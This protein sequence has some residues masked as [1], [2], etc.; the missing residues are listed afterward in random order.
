MKSAYFRCSAALAA[1]VLSAAG[2][3]KLIHIGIAVDDGEDEVEKA[4]AAGGT[5][6][7]ILSYASDDYTGVK[8]HDLVAE[9]KAGSTAGRVWAI[10]RELE[11]GLFF[12]DGSEWHRAETGNFPDNV[13][14]DSIFAAADRVLVLWKQRSEKPML[15]LG[16]H[17]EGNHKILFSV[18][19][20]IPEPTV[21]QMR[22]GEIFITGRSATVL[23]YSGKD[24]LPVIT[25]LPEESF[26][27]PIPMH[28]GKV[29]EDY[30][31]VR[32][33]DDETGRYWIWSQTM[34]GDDRRKRLRG[35]L[36]LEGEDKF[37][38]R[39]VPFVGPD[40]PVIWVKQ[41]KKGRMF[42]AVAG[43]GFFKFDV[44]DEK[45]NYG[46]SSLESLRY[47]ER[48]FEAGGKWYI[49]ATPRPTEYDVEMSKALKSTL[50]LRTTLFYDPEVETST[51][52]LVDGDEIVQ[53][54]RK[55]DDFPDFNWFDR[56]VVETGEGFWL[57]ANRGKLAY[58]PFGREASIRYLSEDE[59]LPL[60][61]PRRLVRWDNESMIALDPSSGKSC[62]VPNAP[63]EKSEEISRPEILNTESMLIEDTEGRVFGWM[64][65][66][67][68]F[69]RWEDGEWNDLPQPELDTPVGGVHLAA[70][71]HGRGWL[72]PEND[73]V[74]AVFDPDDGEWAEFGSFR[75]ALAAKMK[76]ADRIRLGDYVGHMP[77][78]SD[79][80]PPRISF[81]GFDANVRYFDGEKWTQ[82]PLSTIAGK[83]S[84]ITAAPFFRD[85]GRLALPIE[86]RLWSLSPEG[87]WNKEESGEE[88]KNVPLYIR[89]LPDL[90]TGADVSGAAAGKITGAA[91]DR[92]GVCWISNSEGLLWK[93]IPGTIVSVLPKGEESP[94]R[95]GDNIREVV[96]DRDGTAFLRLEFGFGQGRHAVIERRGG[97][98]AAEVKIMSVDGDMVRLGL[99]DAFRHQW[100]I[101]GGEWSQ[102]T[103]EKSVAVHG[104][105][106]GKHEIE[107]R[108]WTEE[109]V[110]SVEIA[111]AEFEVT[112]MD[113][114]EFDRLLSV[115]EGES[116]L[117]K[118]EAARRIASQGK[119]VLPR[120]AAARKNAADSLQWWIDAVV[121]RVE[122]PE[123]I[124]DR[125]R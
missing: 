108:A 29:S 91:Y 110:S 109:L 50:S 60:D 65:G 57:C 3:D 99:G 125:S 24:G 10:A 5:V 73:G 48:V 102:A 104:L 97:L 53:L 123:S 68:K 12:F 13:Y 75:E 42:F 79:A 114:T 52:F 120:L 124:Q 23:R 15:Y 119:A 58:V 116:I 20:T 38:V 34:R 105:L 32:V 11:R 113:E 72:V 92:F 117:E 59:G 6:Y 54:T 90:P 8:L 27:P 107:A 45:N 96:V 30:S 115:F 95:K 66:G 86:D 17:R 43:G 4:V 28:D 37:A 55:L 67:T 61:N 98:P 26:Y 18:P 14:P 19:D 36:T 87:E 74:A 62:L 100:R 2:Q 81:V 31:P 71:G 64:D 122:R 121:Q 46:A 41:W 89:D 94:L 93:A 35:G 112:G 63:P 88:G 33:V 21:A 69:R 44:Q 77:V 84:K 101:N 25:V 40:N 16:E 103:G 9:Q 83:E 80:D 56:S 85:D 82:F 47:I 78:S 22:S 118:E 70:D 111:S 76:P 39:D 1:L 51:L 7:P 106:P 49:V